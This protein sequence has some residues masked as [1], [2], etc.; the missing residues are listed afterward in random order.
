LSST[1]ASIDNANI[2]TVRTTDMGVTVALFVSVCG[3][4]S[5]SRMAQ[6]RVRARVSP[7]R[8]CS[9]RSGSVTG[10]SPSLSVFP[11]QYHS[12]VALY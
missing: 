3:P 8:I 11:C 9:G 7:F 12:T 10:L 4:E 6:T 1:F 2:P 5:F